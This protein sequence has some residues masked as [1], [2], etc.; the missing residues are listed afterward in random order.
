MIPT[1]QHSEKGRTME[2]VKDWQLPGVSGEGKMNRGLT[3][4]F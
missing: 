3:E 4:D 1:M 2:T